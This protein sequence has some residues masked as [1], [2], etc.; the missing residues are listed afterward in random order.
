M[1]MNLAALLSAGSRLFLPRQQPS[2]LVTAIIALLLSAPTALHAQ[3]VSGL[4]IGSGLGWDDLSGE[5]ISDI[6][7]ADQDTSAFNG[8]VGFG[9]GVAAVA[10]AGWGFGNGLRAEMEINFRTNPLMSVSGSSH[11]GGHEYKYGA[12]ANAFYDFNYGWPVT[13]YV[14]AGVGWQVV[15][16]DNGAITGPGYYIQLSHPQSAFAYQAIA[17]VAWKL[18][19]RGLSLTA[20]YRFLDAIGTRQIYGQYYIGSTVPAANAYFHGDINNALLLGVR[21]E[22]GSVATAPAK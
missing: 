13:P 9:N 4:Y 19:V 10:S 15:G 1:K 22:F 11:A 7:L 8:P 17:G 16:I 12:M 6:S 14:G 21:Y 20:E 3:P 18:P 2:Y 5:T